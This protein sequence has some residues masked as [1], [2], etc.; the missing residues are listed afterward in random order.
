MA[1]RLGAAGE[2]DA[3][4]QRMGG[5]GPAARLSEA[6]DDGDD[7]RREPGLLYQ[8]PELQHR[9]RSV[10]GRLEDDGVAR[11]EGRADLHRDQD[12]VDRFKIHLIRQ[13]LAEATVRAYRGSW[14]I[15]AKSIANVLYA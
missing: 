12:L 5:Q 4:D 6:R 3:R 8:S 2:A 9:R 15:S 11:R 13:D 10:L 14:H 7:T 1:C